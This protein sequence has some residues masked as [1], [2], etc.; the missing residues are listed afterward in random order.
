MIPEYNPY[1]MPFLV[2]FIPPTCDKPPTLYAVMETIANGD[3]DFMDDDQVAIRDLPK[4]TRK[5]IFNFDYPLS[6]H[7]NKEDFEILILKH[8]MQRR[9][10]FETVTVFRISLDAKLNEIMP[11]INKMFDAL[12]NWD[13]FKSGESIHRS[14]YENRETFSTSGGTNKMET[15]SETEANNESRDSELPQSH[16][17]NVA[18]KSYLTNYGMTNNKG[19]DKS[20]QTGES[21]GTNEGTDS[22]EYSET[23]EHTNANK[24]EI[25]KE[26]QN[27]IKSIYTIL[28]KELDLLF[29]SIL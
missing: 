8:Y 12:D 27:N 19:K 20:T 1:Y 9:I 22:K 23:I 2:P 24:I 3:K 25:M 13:I 10:G 11:M 29:Y 18:N 4:A 6:E 7:I 16:L 17:E 5:V 15:E 26:M 14:G 28:F 21:S